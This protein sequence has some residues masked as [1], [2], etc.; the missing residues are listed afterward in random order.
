MIRNSYYLKLTLFTT[1]G[2]SLLFLFVLVLN[3]AVARQKRYPWDHVAPIEDKW[4]LDQQ[5]DVAMAE[6][7]AKSLTFQT[8][9][10]ERGKQNFPEFLKFHQYIRESAHYQN[11]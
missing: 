7:L 2:V 10:Y 1:I 4:V 11:V 3:T 8:I 5:R 6:R 9:S